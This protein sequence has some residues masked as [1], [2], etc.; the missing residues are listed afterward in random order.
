M[1]AQA[2][3]VTITVGICDPIGFR[4]L[5]IQQEDSYLEFY[6]LPASADS[7]LE[8]QAKFDAL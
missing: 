8:L 5:P 4:A 1:E 7:S 3:K 2:T 6:K